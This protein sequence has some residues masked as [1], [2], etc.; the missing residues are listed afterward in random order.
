MP[1]EEELS[2]FQLRAAKALAMGGE[3][4]LAERKAQGVLNA[5]ERINHL[6]DTGTF[7]ESGLFAVS[8][9]PEAR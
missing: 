7:L 5:R 3:R 2:E 1:F 4:K 6:A 8:K 9:R